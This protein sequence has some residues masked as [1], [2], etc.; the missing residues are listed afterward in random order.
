VLGAA[1]W[2][3]TVTS[4]VDIAVN[5]V[6]SYLRLTGY[7]T[8]SEFEVQRRN[9]EGRFTTVTDIDIMAIRMPGAVYIGDPHKPADYELLEIHDPALALEDDVVDVI[10]GEVKQGAAELNAGIKDHAVLHTMLR[11]VQALYDE[12]VEVV[13]RGL[14]RGLVHRSPARSG[15]AIRTR[16]VAFGRSPETS[17]TVISLSH[18][19]TT[20]LAFFEQHEDAMRALQFREPAPAFL[21][22]LLKSGFDIEQ[23]P[24]GKWRE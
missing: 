3:A 8:L 13:I 12:P 11:R 6:E 22:L 10:I 18:I 17:E 24:R 15:G 20:M 9:D 23:E 4:L 5:L 14:Q 7:L 1:A 16:L 2:G 21:R 19:V